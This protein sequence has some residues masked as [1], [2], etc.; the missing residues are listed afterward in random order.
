M[1]L[2]LS[3]SKSE[4]L[5]NLSSIFVSFGSSVVSPSPMPRFIFSLHASM[6]NPFGYEQYPGLKTMNSGFLVEYVKVKHVKQDIHPPPSVPLGPL[7]F[8][9]PFLSVSTSFTSFSVISV[10]I[11]CSPRHDATTTAPSMGSLVSASITLPRNVVL[12]ADPPKR[13]IVTRT[14]VSPFFIAFSCI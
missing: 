3:D 8:H 11:A 13:T 14:T 7:I 10:P 2:P 9:S 1:P 5:R 6:K 12:H 4:K